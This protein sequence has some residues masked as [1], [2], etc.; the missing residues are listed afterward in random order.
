M[1]PTRNNPRADLEAEHTPAAIEGRLQAPIPHSYLRDFIYGAIDGAVTTF[2]IVCGVEGARLPAA[3]VVVLGV[4]NLVADGMSMAASNFL[5]T[6]AEQ[7]LRH[8]ARREEEAHIA[9]IPEGEREEIRQIFANKGFAGDD[10]ERAVKI[11]TSDINRWVDTMLQ[12]EH[13]LAL[14]GPS[15]FRAAV[16]TFVAFVV[17][18]ALPLLAFVLDL[19]APEWGVNAFAASAVL[20]G[21]AF[22]VVGA[23]KSRVVGQRWYVAALETLSIGGLAAATAY[24]IGAMLRGLA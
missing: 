12:D 21:A 23:L 4:A 1:T 18:G 9:T 13:G 15:P 3:I 17:I 11:I 19:A 8:R 6:R 14:R 5:G 7:Q 2:A 24:A 10:L 22:I 16:A 20:T